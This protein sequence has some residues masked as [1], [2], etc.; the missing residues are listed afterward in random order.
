MNNK[1]ESMQ[2]AARIIRGMAMAFDEDP[3]QMVS[4]GEVAK[5]L[6]D[7]AEEL[8]RQAAQ[9]LS[10]MDSTSEGMEQRNDGPEQDDGSNE[11]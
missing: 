2:R 11:D 4:R 5:T 1:I 6:T 3:R 10:E 8:E 9:H 7:I